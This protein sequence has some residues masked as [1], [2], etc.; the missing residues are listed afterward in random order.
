MPVSPPIR[1]PEP[2]AQID[3]LP[4]TLRAAA[5]HAAVNAGGAPGPEVAF[6][7]LQECGNRRINAVLD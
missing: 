4:E 2:R 1:Q 3:L 6:V 7:Q 5:L